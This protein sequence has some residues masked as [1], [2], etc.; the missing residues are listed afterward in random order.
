MWVWVW[1][2]SHW[3]HCHIIT[4]HGNYHQ[5]PPSSH[6][7]KA[8]WKGTEALVTQGDAGGMG[9][10]Q[11]SL[12]NG[13]LFRLFD[14]FMLTHRDFRRFSLGYHAFR[15][16]RNTRGCRRDGAMTAIP[17]KVCY[18]DFLI[19]LSWFIDILGGFHSVFTRFEAL[20]TQGGAGGMGYDSNP[21]KGMLLRFFE[22]FMLIYRD[23][24]RFSL[25][26]HAFWSSRHTR[27]HRRDWLWQQSLQNSG[28]S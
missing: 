13:M 7:N 1:V 10:W 9:L 12:P 4:N 22:H 25:C 15:S 24:R 8:A 14:H 2:P 26:F 21:S 20:V 3:S 5:P 19:I 28:F 11:P 27:Q 16:S 23:F 18:F 17:P 6:I